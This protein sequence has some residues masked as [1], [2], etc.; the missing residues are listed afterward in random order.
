[1]LNGTLFCQ[2]SL[3]NYEGMSIQLNFFKTGLESGF[4]NTKSHLL[5][6]ND[7]TIERIAH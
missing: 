3:A 1:M 4:E 5:R 7:Y 6:F 2:A